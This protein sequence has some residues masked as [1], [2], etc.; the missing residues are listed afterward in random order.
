MSL[1]I[2]GILLTMQGMAA[3]GLFLMQDEL[4]SHLAKEYLGT[5][6]PSLLIL[7]GIRKLVPL[8]KEI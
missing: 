1:F 3:L 8:H 7:A 4:I 6:A 5:V 2:K